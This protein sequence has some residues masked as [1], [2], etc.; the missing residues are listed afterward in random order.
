MGWADVPWLLL[1]GLAA[2]EAGAALGVVIALRRRRAPPL[3]DAECPR[4]T[5]IVALRGADPFLQDCL[6]AAMRQDYPDYQ[7]LA[8]VD[9]ADDPS[10]PTLNKIAAEAPPGRLR[11]DVLRSPGATC[12]LKCSSLVQAIGQLD[13]A[14]ELVALLDADCVTH[15]TW[16]R[17]LAAPFADA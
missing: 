2:V 16:L 9:R 3:A 17:E 12:S 8:I 5:V 4:A 1:V 7:V 13:E 10:W 6:Q 15:A 14:C 11:A